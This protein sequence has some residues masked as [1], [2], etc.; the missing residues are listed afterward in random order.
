MFFVL[1]PLGVVFIYVAALTARYHKDRFFLSA[2]L[3]WLVFSLGYTI[4]YQRYFEAFTLFF[5]LYY[6]LQAGT[7]TRW[8]WVGPI[9]LVVV[10]FVA[11]MI[12]HLVVRIS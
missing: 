4:F 11:D 3:V 1:L 6:G 12:H 9:T 7:K 5:I 2:F 10:F 8:S